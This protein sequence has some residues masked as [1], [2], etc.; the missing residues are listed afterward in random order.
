ME[1]KKRRK[2]R[3]AV[4]GWL[5][6]QVECSISSFFFVSLVS[7]FFFFMAVVAVIVSGG[8]RIHLRRKGG[9][10]DSG[11]HFPSPFHFIS[12]FFLFSSLY[13]FF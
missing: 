2:G 5:L 13:F 9:E 7:I 11:M 8:G 4:R 3:A 1:K 10:R 12:V 6:F